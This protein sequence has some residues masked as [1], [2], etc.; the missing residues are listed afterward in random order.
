MS[1][2]NRPRRRRRRGAA[3]PQQRPQKQRPSKKEHR[4][5]KPPKMKMVDVH[6][7]MGL[8]DHLVRI[9]LAGWRMLIS[10]WML[11]KEDVILRGAFR[12]QEKNIVLRGQMGGSL[13]VRPPKK[14]TNVAMF[15]VFKAKDLRGE[16]LEKA[17]V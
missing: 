9:P 3:A 1:D 4:E 17:G 7:R 10:D 14:G 2:E 13:R 8:E 5:K 15:R 12:D 16:I 11:G 6:I